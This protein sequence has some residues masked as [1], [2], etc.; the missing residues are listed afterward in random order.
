MIKMDIEGA[1]LDALRGAEG[2]ISKYKPLL[3][4]CVYHKR[5]DLLTIPEYIKSIVP[6]Y[7]LFLRAYERTTTELVLYAVV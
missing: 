5:D 4:I 2:T 1:E 6:E 7:R 3:A